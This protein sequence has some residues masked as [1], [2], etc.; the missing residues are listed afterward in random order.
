MQPTLRT[1]TNFTSVVLLG[2]LLPIVVAHSHEDETSMDMEA[3][4]SRPM[5]IA[6]NV[7]TAAP[8]SYFHYGHSGFM[9]AHIAL[10]TIGWVFVLPVGR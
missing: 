5:I 1:Y 7:T 8:E 10:M 2:L 4:P 9:V 3:S 6:S